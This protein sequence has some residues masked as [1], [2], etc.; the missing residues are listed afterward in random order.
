M[1]NFNGLNDESLWTGA[2]VV[3]A[4][5]ETVNQFRAIGWFNVAYS[6]IGLG[7]LLIMF[8]GEMKCKKEQCLQF[9]PNRRHS[10]IKRLGAL[11]IFISYTV[12]YGP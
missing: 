1:L 11:S 10:S 4:Q 3:F 7:L 5:F 6:T 8:H 2:T 9:C 12:L